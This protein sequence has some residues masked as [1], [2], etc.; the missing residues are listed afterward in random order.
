VGKKIPQD[1]ELNLDNFKIKPSPH[2][3]ILGIIFDQHLTFKKDIENTVSKCQGL[4]MILRKCVKSL[5]KELL[6]LLYIGIIRSKLEYAN[7][8]KASVSKTHLHKL[9]VVQKICVRIITN[10]PRDAHS[11]PLIVSLGLDA[12]EA[13]RKKHIVKYVKRCLSNKFHPN[14]HNIFR[15]NSDGKLDTD[16]KTRIASGKRRFGVIGQK[17]Y[18]ESI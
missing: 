18:N 5:P 12:L 1:I 2:V 4:V 17:F 9:E 7:S 10:S 8:I 15:L 11:D 16:I 13:R 14:F 6:K 3:N